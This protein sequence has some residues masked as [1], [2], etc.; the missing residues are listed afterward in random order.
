MEVGH[1]LALLQESKTLPS[2]LIPESGFGTVL[3]AWVPPWFLPVCKVLSLVPREMVVVWNVK[4]WTL[5]PA[6]P[7]KL[8]DL[9]HGS[10][11]L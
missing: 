9:G 10:Y 5:D 8:C 4:T 7:L 11:P 1:L 6:C 3:R 2:S